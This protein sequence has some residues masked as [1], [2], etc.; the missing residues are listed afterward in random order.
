MASDR[1]LPATAR[2]CYGRCRVAQPQPDVRNFDLYLSVLPAHPEQHLSRY[3][4]IPTRYAP[5]RAA[6]D[7]H[8]LERELSSLR[9]ATARFPAA[10]T[11]ARMGAARYPDLL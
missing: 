11:T 6:G 9:I 10:G 8:G 1:F 3:G 4:S 7:L 5:R 2:P